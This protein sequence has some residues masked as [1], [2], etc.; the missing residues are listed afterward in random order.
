VG[1]DPAECHGYLSLAR[2]ACSQEEVS[3]SGRSPIQ[4]NPEGCD[5][6]ECDREDL[7]MRKVW[8]TRFCRNMGEKNVIMRLYRKYYTALL[9]AVSSTLLRDGSVLPQTLSLSGF[10]SKSDLLPNC[11]CVAK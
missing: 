8:P 6:S 3:A 4:R 2:V 11:C 5:V 7:I 9:N 10:Q 1:L